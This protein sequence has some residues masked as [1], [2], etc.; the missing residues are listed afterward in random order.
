MTDTIP[1]LQSVKSCTSSGLIDIVSN[2]DLG[3]SRESFVDH[4][5]FAGHHIS[6][7]ESQ[8]PS[9][10]VRFFSNPLRPRHISI[11]IEKDHK[12][13]LSI[14]EKKNIKR[15]EIFDL[16]QKYGSK[17]TSL[18]S[19]TVKLFHQLNFSHIS[20]LKNALTQF[21]HEDFVENEKRMGENETE[22]EYNTDKTKAAIF[23]IFDFIQQQLHTPAYDTRALAKDWFEILQHAKLQSI[24]GILSGMLWEAS[25]N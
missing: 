22:E 16:Y 15:L 10:D 18:K 12:N 2:E 9:F 14:S 4:N 13:A 21:F 20:L 8:F 6:K 17:I 7:N 1:V 25:K 23:E 11:K 24:Y 3:A 19:R 5:G